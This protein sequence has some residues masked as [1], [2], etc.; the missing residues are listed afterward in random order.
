LRRPRCRLLFG[1]PKR[2]VK[3]VE[4]VAL[5]I[6]FFAKKG[7][8]PG[9]TIASH[10]KICPVDFVYRTTFR[11]CLRPNPT[12]SVIERGFRAPGIARRSDH[13]YLTS[14]CGAETFHQLRGSCS[15]P[16]CGS[17]RSAVCTGGMARPD[18]NADNSSRRRVQ[19]P[20]VHAFSWRAM[21]ALT[22]SR[23]LSVWG[24]GS[25]THS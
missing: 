3:M 17:T 24:P 8:E 18:L 9:R 12:S 19:H 7:N 14:C 25:A 15:A 6:I 10:H 20:F 2:A 5:F 13:R 16:R 23:A 22:T 1:L 4:H 21:K 11:I